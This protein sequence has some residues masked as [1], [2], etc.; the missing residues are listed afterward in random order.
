MKKS[1]LVSMVAFCVL[2]LNVFAANVTFNDPNLLAAVQTQYE[3]Q[4]GSPLS[5]P[6]QDT[7]LAN[8]DF[9][10]LDASYLGITDLTG[11]EACTSLTSLNLTGNAITDLSPIS[12][13]T[14]LEILLLG[15]NQ[16]ID[17][18]D[19]ASLTGLQILDIGYNQISDIYALSSLTGLVGLNLGFGTLDM[20]EGFDV[21]ATGVN[22]LDDA[23]L[24]IL[25]SLVNLQVLSIGGLENVTSIDFLSSL[26]NLT[27]LWMGNNPIADWT[28]LGS[29]MGNLNTFLEIN[30]GMSQIAL[31]TYVANMTSITYIDENNPGLLGIGFEPGITDLSSLS[32]LNPSMAL[33]GGLGISDIDVVQNWTNLIMFICNS[34]GITNIDALV[35]L[36][37]LEI[38][39]LGDN[40]IGPTMFS[41]EVTAPLGSLLGL[42]L[43][44][45]VLENLNGIEYM[46]NL[47][48]F[49][50]V[51][52]Q[53][54]DISAL[55]L[56]GSPKNTLEDLALNN[57]QIT[58]ITPL[59]NYISLRNVILRD[60]LIEDFSPL[61]N[62]EG[63]GDGDSIDITNNPVPPELC[64]IVDQLVAKVQPNG[65]VG[66]EGVCQ[67]TL[68]MEIEGEG[69][70][71]PGVG[72]YN[73]Y[74]G[75][76]IYI[77][78]YPKADSGQAFDHWEI[79]NE[80]TSE[81]EF[82]TDITS[83]FFDNVQESMK[84]KAVFTA[85][86]YT[87]TFN[88]DP[89]ST[90]TGSVYPLEDG[91][92][93]YTYKA[94]QMANLS[95]NP[96]EGSCFAQWTGDAASYGSSDYAG[97]YMDSDKTVGALFS[98]ECYTL[99]IEIIG[100]GVLSP[101]AGI[102]QYAKGAV[103]QIYAW[104]NTGY[105]LDHW[106][107]GDGNNL[108]SS[109]PLEVTITED[110]TIRAI[111][112]KIPS[113]N[114][115]INVNGSGTTNPTPGTYNY[116]PGAVASVSAMPDSG[117][118][119]NG[120][121]GD[122]GSANP[123]DNPIQIQMDSDKYI[124]ANFV[125]PE[126]IVIIS[127]VGPGTTD[128]APG[129]YGYMSGQWLFPRAIPEA[130][131]AF[132]GWYENGELIHDF[133]VYPFQVTSDRNIEARF[134]EPDYLVTLN[135][136]GNGYTDPAPGIYGYK[137]GQWFVCTAQP[138]PNYALQY[139]EVKKLDEE[140]N[141]V[142]TEYR[143]DLM[144][145]LQAT[146]DY[147]VNAVFAMCD[148][149]V[150]I[151]MAGTGTGNIT[152]STGAYCFLDGKELGLS[153]ETIEG[154]YFGGWELI[155]NPLGSPETTRVYWFNT[156]LT[157]DASYDIVAY[158]NSTGYLFDF[159]IEG[160][161][162]VTVGDESLPIT[163]NTYALAS[164]FQLKLKATPSF[165]KVFKGWY[166][167]GEF[168]SK[169]TQFEI[170][171]NNDLQL[172]AKFGEPNQY[173]LIITVE[174]GQ[175]S[176]V[177]IPGTYTYNEG[178]IVTIEANPANGWV[179]GSW[180]GDTDGTTEI[181]EYR[182][183]RVPMDKDRNIGVIF[184]QPT[185][186]EGTPE[187]TVEGA[188]EGTVEGTVEGAVEGTVEGTVEGAVEGTTEGTVEGEIGPHSADRDGD[189]VINLSEL[190]RVIQF[191]NMGGY[192]C[193]PNGEDGYNGGYDGDHTCTPHSSD[194]DPQDWM[195]DLS[196]LLRLIQF[197]NM[198]GYH[199]CPG[200]GEDGYCP[201]LVG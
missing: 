76:P 62:N 17:I 88:F 23:D 18:G 174:E 39:D 36:T 3:A 22:D 128:P 168:Q 158:F 37:N 144:L 86:G 112:I 120:W 195:I 155:K 41:A 179:L 182:R 24:T 135:I 110:I 172:T 34:T 92:G 5:D 4:V 166:L 147:E 26:P 123:M 61:V 188:V 196:E 50:A 141:V 139:W 25:N 58:D 10:Y 8:T 138:D 152:P 101:P 134:G 66:R 177:P 67:I 56:D 197:F 31:D 70:I 107:D 83:Y 159:D 95:A 84:L 176:T 154:N 52:N 185:E 111:F 69:H 72:V 97:I 29:V 115:T 73:I 167:N 77:N 30:C 130:G 102:Y 80:A 94:G 79:W 153:A 53:I 85:G 46:P 96:D 38:A 194:Y 181:P 20:Y 19:L 7:E 150:N 157:V 14:S 199:P 15:K 148:W 193:D 145:A 117:W 87:L 151:S 81:Y 13:L 161:G 33:I 49:N 109:S 104:G 190:L 113:Y 146:S 82:L 78:A 105:M 131:K 143:Y 93:V 103:R 1:M 98:N 133:T 32:G 136:V 186:G 48:Y 173:V 183:I 125:S 121:T 60:N 68:T 64:Y 55:D 42:G 43:Y 28:P 114:L 118:L 201:G 142:S 45:N 9:Q 27:Q 129:T 162:S 160:D 12:G 90:G 71:E 74:I 171:I 47:I 126:F 35:G 200:I 163:P 21:S 169:D 140:G 100:N 11:L 137:E 198:G 40:N 178:A 54:S 2:S 165:G 187:G 156:T 16:L 132:L 127:V 189:G 149:N 75:S 106:E 6:P 51:D 175:G 57:N 108:G 63:I 91:P 116:S 65:N 59:E 192:H 184:V 164:N 99:T 44:N 122:I 119:F 89:A 180:T 170:T 191:F 124:T